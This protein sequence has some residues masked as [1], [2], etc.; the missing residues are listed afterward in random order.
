[1]FAYGCYSS[2]LNGVEQVEQVFSAK[3]RNR[4]HH[5]GSSSPRLEQPGAT[6]EP[7][8]SETLQRPNKSVTRMGMDQLCQDHSKA[9]DPQELS[10]IIILLVWHRM[11]S[12]FFTKSKP[13]LS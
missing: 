1:M 7:W 4:P 3:A 10:D 9:V 12:G 6:E 13:Q 5:S 2:A 11:E 8:Q